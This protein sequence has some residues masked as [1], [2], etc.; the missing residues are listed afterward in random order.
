MITWSWS[1]T[2]KRLFTHCLFEKADIPAINKSAH[3]R[4]HHA[5]THRHPLPSNTNLGHLSEREIPFLIWN[6]YLCTKAF[7][8]ELYCKENIKETLEKSLSYG[9]GG[10]SKIY[11][12]Q[13]FSPQLLM[14]SWGAS[15]HLSVEFTRSSSC[16]ETLQTGREV[17]SG[18]AVV[19]VVLGE[20][21]SFSLVSTFMLC[22]INPQNPSG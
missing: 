1:L 20:L 12:S 18:R 7:P 21:A 10:G 5:G 13:L 22:Y 4:W 19:F 2:V 16:A 3:T 17:L 9:E 6:T 8:T 11:F 15:V 14:S